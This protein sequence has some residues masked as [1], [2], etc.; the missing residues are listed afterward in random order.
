MLRTIVPLVCQSR[1]TLW[2]LARF[3]SQNAPGLAEN[4][5]PVAFSS[6]GSAT[7]DATGESSAHDRPAVGQC[8]QPRQF[9]VPEKTVPPSEVQAEEE[10]AAEIKSDDPRSVDAGNYQAGG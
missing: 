9:V 5:A 6:G 4:A 3:S 1:I 8:L 7:L 10:E 2:G